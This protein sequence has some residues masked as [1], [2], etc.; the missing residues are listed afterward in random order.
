M[1]DVEKAAFPTAFAL[2]VAMSALALKLKVQP[3]P[4]RT[5]NRLP[6]SARAELAIR[7]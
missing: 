2:R 4:N 7:G 6:N 1:V 5:G 3:M